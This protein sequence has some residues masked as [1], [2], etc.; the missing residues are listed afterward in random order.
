MK[1]NLNKILEGMKENKKKITKTISIVVGIVLIGSGIVGGTIY[2]YAK[3]NI[4]YSEKQLEEIAIKKIPGEVIKV[5][6]ELD[7]EEA[8]FEYTFQIKD[9]ED[10]LQEITISSKSGAITDIETNEH[11]L[12]DNDNNREDD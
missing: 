4:N 12:E 8:T 2:S 3:S 10:M 9:N 5:E 7:F 6:K 11:E 1:D